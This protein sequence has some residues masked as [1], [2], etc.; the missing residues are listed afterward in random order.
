MSVNLRKNKKILIIPVILMVGGLW[1]YSAF[2]QD[3]NAN[4]I[5]D[6]PGLEEKLNAFDHLLNIGIVAPLTALSLTGASFLSRSSETNSKDPSNT[7]LMD[8]AR[9]NLIKAFVIFLSCTIAVFVFDFLEVM[10]NYSRILV[11]IFDLVIS[12]SLLFIGFAY[13]VLQ[14]KRCIALKQNSRFSEK[15]QTLL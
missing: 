10:T 4:S 1:F 6:I 3:A 12:Y 8:M 11:L 5:L 9:I 14:L 2:A 15:N 7:K 13:L